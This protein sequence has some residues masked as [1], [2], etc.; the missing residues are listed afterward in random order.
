MLLPLV[1]LGA[2]Q[3][4]CAPPP[5]V[6]WRGWPDQPFLV[7]AVWDGSPPAPAPDGNARSGEGGR[8]RAAAQ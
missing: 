6:A 5:A 8:A 3:W 7:G 2:A 1:I 4:F